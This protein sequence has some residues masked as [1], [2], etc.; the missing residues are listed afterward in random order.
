MKDHELRNLFR[1]QGT[2]ARSQVGDQTTTHSLHIQMGVGF[3]EDLA[4]FAWDLRKSTAD[5]RS[6]DATPSMKR[7][8]RHVDRFWELLEQAGFKI[9]DHVNQPFDSGQSVQV[10]AF[11]PTLG[12]EKEVVVETVR[13]SVYLHEHR[14]QIGQVIVATPHKSL[15]DTHNDAEHN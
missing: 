8:V 6:A 7:T 5:F 12:V 4:N 3:L 2:D 13:P 1:L 9:Q 11:Q 14:I 15:E 10:L